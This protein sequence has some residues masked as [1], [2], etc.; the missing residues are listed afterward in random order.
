MD[1]M[2]ETGLSAHQARAKRLGDIRSGRVSKDYLFPMIMDY[3][4]K[5]KL[6]P[7]YPMPRELAE[8]AH[9][10][11]EKTLGSHR[12]R[13]YSS[14]WKDEMRGRA[15]E[16]VL[17]YSHNFDPDKCKTGKN[18][19]YNYFAMIATMAFIQ[20]LKKCKAYSDSHVQMNPDVNYTENTWDVNQDH[21][22]DVMANTPNTD[23][24]D[25]GQF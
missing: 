3:K 5:K 6:L 10:I 12:W 16:H 4:A 21:V 24:L 7:E 20:S 22:P 17:K 14:D 9:I 13:S 15:L 1:E 2:N 25:W 23:N 18:D 8:V 19:P 11:I